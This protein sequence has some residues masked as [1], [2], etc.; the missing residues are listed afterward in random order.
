MRAA[1]QRKKEDITV[2]PTIVLSLVL[3]MA[4]SAPATF[5]GEPQASGPVMRLTLPEKPDRQWDDTCRRVYEA[6]ER[7]ARYLL[8]ELHP[9]SEDG[10]MLLL[11]D[12]RSG[13]HWVRPNTGTVEGLAFLYRFGPYDPEVVGIARDEL[14]KAKIVPM[15]RYLVA[16][17]VTGSR[18]TSEGKPWGDAWQSAFWA[19]MLGRAAWWTWSDLPEEVREGVRR[20]VAHEADRI[21]A[22]EPPHQ[23]ERDTKAE[24]NAWNSRILSVA[25]LLL[26]EDARRGEWEKAFQR[27]V[28]SSYL[29]PADEHNSAVVDGRPVSEQFT[30]ANIYDDFTLEN[31]GIV[32]PDYMTCFNLSLGCALDYG[33]SGRK[34]PQALWHN[35]AGIYEN[36]KWFLLPDGG[37]VYPNG[38]DWE[39]F[40]NPSWINDQC[41][42]AVFA[43]DPQA[44]PPMMVC[45]EALEKMQGRF[46]SGTVY[47]PGEFF[48]AS[49]QTDLFDSLGQ[50][51]LMLQFGGPT[52]G[53]SPD[54]VGV[55]RLDA[56]KIIVSRTPSVVHTLS[57]GARVMGQCV[58][59]RRDR[60]VSPDPRS[61]IGHVTLAGGEQPLRVKLIDA[62]VNSDAA[63][64]DAK[65]VISHG[66]AIR[67]ELEFRS[68]GSVW[69]VCET[70]TAMKDVTTE[71]IATGLVGILNN[72]TWVYEKGQRE[73][74][75][76]GRKTTIRALS[77]Q[78]LESDSARDL[79][80]D[81]ALEITSREPLRVRYF[82][83]AQA[84]RARA[85]DRLYL[86]YVGGKRTWKAGQ[87]ISRYAVEMRC[88]P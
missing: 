38:Q 44:I 74:A 52:K 41:L 27:W 24:E 70:L 9:W 5:A 62:H 1:S 29:R 73:I 21:A 17:H 35:V 76:N 53:E 15:M 86:N 82:G 40:R 42:V 77:G 78:S 4:G 28:M 87:E 46:D 72:A 31:H 30:G 55:R 75:I 57:W 19:Q 61:G 84:E 88:V 83:A 49:T 39:L 58:L 81:G 54:R 43:H 60:L 67:A 50:T 26:P 56:G 12:S 59:N 25:M 16:T 65:V 68:A 7:L 63:G 13:E 37:F 14:L 23:I 3:I 69:S 64:F 51:W 66:K 33:M 80:V 71:E 36:L 8:S 11:T 47:G 18:A 20:V 45:M 34:A 85:T 6:T 32:H 48:F 10:T 22:A 2:R 79:V